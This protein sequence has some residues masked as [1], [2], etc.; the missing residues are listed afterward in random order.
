MDLEIAPILKVACRL[1]VK[2]FKEL[3]A[4]EGDYTNVKRVLEP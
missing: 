1:F 3:E 4:A 2:V